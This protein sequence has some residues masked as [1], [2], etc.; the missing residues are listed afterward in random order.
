MNQ[1]TVQIFNQNS[2]QLSSNWTNYM[3][4]RSEEGCM[5]HATNFLRFLSGLGEQSCELIDVDTH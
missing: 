2:G 5:P 1:E 3:H 4:D